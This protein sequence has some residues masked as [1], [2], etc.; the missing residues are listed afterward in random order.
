[1]AARLD[2]L[3]A[4]LAARLRKPPVLFLLKIGDWSDRTAAEERYGEMVESAAIQSADRAF[5]LADG[6]GHG[7]IGPSP[8]GCEYMDTHEVRI[9]E[10]KLPAKPL[11]L[12]K[13]PLRLTFQEPPAPPLEEPPPPPRK[14][15]DN[16]AEVEKAEAAREKF[17]RPIRYPRTG[18]I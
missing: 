5:V 16:E 18:A 12:P 6:G 11:A 2:K 8:R 15:F 9:T 14:A 7:V 13:P 17:H 4:L 3:E 1:L 10:R